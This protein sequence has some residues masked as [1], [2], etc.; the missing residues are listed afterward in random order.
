MMIRKFV[1]LNDGN[2]I[3][4]FGLGVYIVRDNEPNTVVSGTP[5]RVLKYLET[6]SETGKEV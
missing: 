3:Q 2:K 6:V 4:Q 5:A 1:A